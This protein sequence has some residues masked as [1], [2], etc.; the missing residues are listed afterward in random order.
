MEHFVSRP[1]IDFM[2]NLIVENLKKRKSASGKKKEVSLSYLSYNSI[3][4]YNKCLEKNLE[5]FPRYF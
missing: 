3:S 2:I 5:S 1:L 4:L